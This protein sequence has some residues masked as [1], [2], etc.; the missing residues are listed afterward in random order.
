MF[1]PIP[2]IFQD[3]TRVYGTGLRIISAKIS[4]QVND[5]IDEVSS[6]VAQSISEKS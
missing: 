1:T 6:I 3:S 4:R 5:C 2:Q